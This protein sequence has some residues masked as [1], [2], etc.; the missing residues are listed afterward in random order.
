MAT[1]MQSK[2]RGLCQCGASFPR[3]ASIEY[4]RGARR[5]TACPAC[6]KPAADAGPDLAQMFD[7]A[8][9]DQCRD[10]C[11]PGL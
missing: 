11:G 4:D 3:G 9:E 1:P 2:Y 7:M 6:K 8:Y 10:A 5:V